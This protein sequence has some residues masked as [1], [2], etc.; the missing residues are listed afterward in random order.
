MN[1]PPLA[2]L[3]AGTS[4]KRPHPEEHR[5][6]AQPYRHVQTSMALRGVSKGEAGTIRAAL[7]LRDA[8]TEAQFC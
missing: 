5:N 1:T 7:M 8:R 3:A 4:L 6:A 2:P